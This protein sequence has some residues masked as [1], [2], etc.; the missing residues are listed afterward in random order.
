MS[1]AAS[2]LMLRLICRL[3]ILTNHIQP[4]L[5]RGRGASRTSYVAAVWEGWARSTSELDNP[6]LGANPN[7]SS[8]INPNLGVGSDARPWRC[9]GSSECR[10][11]AG[12]SRGAEATPALD[13]HAVAPS[14]KG[15]FCSVRVDGCHD[16][17]LLSHRGVSGCVV[18]A[19]SCTFDGVIFFW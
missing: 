4:H 14:H 11:S 10:A 19:G 12:S 9:N 2:V 18:R 15:A 17:S 5:V 7:P 3:L 13:W 6:N 16:I 8:G 1:N